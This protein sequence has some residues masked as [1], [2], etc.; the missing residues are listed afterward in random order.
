MRPGYGTHRSEGV[1]RFDPNPGD[2]SANIKYVTT[3]NGVVY[4]TADD[5]VHGQE[6]W[7]TDGS[8]KG[9]VMVKDIPYPVLVE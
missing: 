7:K 3:M 4:F 1:N 9:T 5:D 6:L 2:E 8:A